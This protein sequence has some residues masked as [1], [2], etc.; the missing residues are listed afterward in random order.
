MTNSSNW[1]WNYINNAFLFKAAIAH[2]SSVTKNINGWKLSLNSYSM[3]IRGKV[4]QRLELSPT[5]FDNI[6]AEM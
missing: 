4:N 6:T 5:L 3:I 2:L 1:T